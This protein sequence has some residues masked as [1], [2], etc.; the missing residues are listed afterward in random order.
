MQDKFENW[1][2]RFN[3]EMIDLKGVLYYLSKEEIADL[4]QYKTNYWHPDGPS[5]W[6]TVAIFNLARRKYP[7]LTENE[8]LMLV[9][10]SVRS[11]I[12]GVVGSIRWHERYMT[13][14]DG[15]EYKVLKGEYE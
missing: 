13:F 14:H 6:M 3:L 5:T 2:D 4:Y 12:K 1:I 7:K 8:H 9:A 11:D 10:H 15:G